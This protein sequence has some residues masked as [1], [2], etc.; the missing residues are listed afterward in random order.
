MVTAIQCQ[1]DQVD[2]NGDGYI[3]LE[4]TKTVYEKENAN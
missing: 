1:L 2:P 3:S 4:E